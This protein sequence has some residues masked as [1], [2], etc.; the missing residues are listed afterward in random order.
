MRKHLPLLSILLLSMATVSA[1]ET[2]EKQ[3][4]D[5]NRWSIDINGGV[6]NPT[7]PFADG[8]AAA[9]LSPFHVDLGGRYMFSPKFGLKLDF[10]Y[11]QFKEESKSEKFD[12]KNYRANLQA[13]VNVGRML[14]FETWTNSLNLQLHGGFGYSIMKF[15]Q[16]VSPL[17]APVLADEDDMFNMIFG[18]TGQVKLSNR[19]ALN[20]DFTIVNNSSQNYTF[21]GTKINPDQRGFDATYYNATVGLSIYLGKNEK[22]ADWYVSTQ[23][24]DDLEDLEKRLGELETGL[25]DSDKDGVPDMYDVEPNSIA[26]VAVNSQGRSIDANQNGVPDEL[27]NYLVQNYG[28]GNGTNGGRNSS[29]SSLATGGN[30]YIKDLINGG[31][32]N[33]YFDFN[34]ASPSKYSLEG[35]NF[36][37]KYLKANPSAKAEII[38]Y[39]D[40]I[41]DANYNQQLSLRRAEAVKAIVEHSGIESSRLTVTAGGVDNS[42]NK[43]SKDARQIVRRVTFKVN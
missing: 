25:A 32:V 24:Q 40:E 22:H 17:S 33:V 18:I 12:T 23:K 4:V 28:P 11:D 41:G 27:E 3:N 6:N 38:G 16:N 13:V 2:E 1:Q 15:D 10:G 8:Y 29:T 35:A 26:G 5:F 43:S 36:V 37:V 21:D 34:S 14:N 31:Y 39:A 7:T 19:V 42:V 20:A 30:A 9:T